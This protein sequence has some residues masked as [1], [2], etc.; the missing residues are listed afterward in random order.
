MRVVIINGKDESGQFFFSFSTHT[1]SGRWGRSSPKLSFIN[2]WILLPSLRFQAPKALQALILNLTRSF[3]PNFPFP[4]PPLLIFYILFPSSSVSI[5]KATGRFHGDGANSDLPSTFFKRS[6]F[7]N[8]RDVGSK[9]R[10]SQR[11]HPFSRLFFK[12]PPP[13]FP[14][15]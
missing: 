9:G 15:S 12:P 11:S 14:P 8:S 13:P 1:Y 10:S 6:P 4:L 2:P 7:L 5:R 3:H